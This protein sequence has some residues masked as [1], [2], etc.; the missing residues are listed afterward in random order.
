M[1]VMAMAAQAKS[2][3]TVVDKVTI[4]ADKK[5]VRFKAAL[6]VADVNLLISA[7]D[8]GGITAQDSPPATDAGSQA[9]AAA[10]P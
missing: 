6:S 10:G 2:L 8:G 5:V 4:S 1:S 3:G 9:G 7:L